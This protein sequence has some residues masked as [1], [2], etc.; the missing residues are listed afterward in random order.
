MVLIVN[1]YSSYF[2]LNE[3]LVSLV[4]GISEAFPISSSS[5]LQLL[6]YLGIT[7]PGHVTPHTDLALHLGS[8]LALCTLFFN[9]CWA[10]IQGFWDVMRMRVTRNRMFFFTLFIASL[11]AIS[12]GFLLHY[13]GMDIKIRQIPA[14]LI[15]LAT[16]TFG[17][18]MYRTDHTKNEARGNPNIATVAYPSAFFIG[19]AQVLAFI[20]GVSRLGICLTAGRLSRYG[21]Q[22]AVHFS[23]LM[24]IVSIG[25]ALLLKTPEIFHGAMDYKTLA[26]TTS[27]TY[28]INLPLMAFFMVCA[29]RRFS[30]APFALYRACLAL[31]WLYP[32]QKEIQAWISF[33]WPF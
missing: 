21:L 14:Y 22:T 19:C 9:D 1:A 20:P 4:Q 13:T 3:F 24:G 28:L 6:T 2:M 26:I 31:V 15:G 27:I 17:Y 32:Y 18:L 30:L 12:I 23:F 33:L 10:L 16:L 8:F 25:G 29:R 11:P 7:D 5:H